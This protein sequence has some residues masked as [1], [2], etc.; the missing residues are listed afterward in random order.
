MLDGRILQKIG[1]SLEPKKLTKEQRNKKFESSL[2]QLNHHWLRGIVRKQTWTAAGGAGAAAAL[3]ALPQELEL[4]GLHGVRV[5]DTG[6]L[7]H[8]LPGKGNDFG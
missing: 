3:P 4:H 1:T 8:T 6:G 2:T 7:Q 5:P